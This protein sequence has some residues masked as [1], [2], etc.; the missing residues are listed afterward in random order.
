MLCLICNLKKNGKNNKKTHA[1]NNNDKVNHLNNNNNDASANNNN[2]NNNNND[3]KSNITLMNGDNIN[4]DDFND[5][6]KPPP[7]FGVPSK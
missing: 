5:W 3:I 6:K 4:K 7:I 1:N 2:N